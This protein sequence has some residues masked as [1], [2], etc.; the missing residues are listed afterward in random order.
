MACSAD[1]GILVLSLLRKVRRSEED[2][3][4]RELHVDGV[5]E[6]G[7]SV[8]SVGETELSAMV[9]VLSGKL[10]PLNTCLSS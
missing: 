5:D 1:C 6:V 2:G 7:L 10:T 9:I 3:G 4:N 8:D